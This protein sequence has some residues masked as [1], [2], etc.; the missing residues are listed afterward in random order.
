MST[1]ER[2][3]VKKLRKFADQELDRKAQTRS[4]SIKT[5]KRFTLGQRLNR[6]VSRKQILISKS[7]PPA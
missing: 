7:D 3:H 2:Y 6:G 4:K 1:K 5:L